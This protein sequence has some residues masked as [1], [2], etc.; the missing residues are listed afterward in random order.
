MDRPNARPEEIDE[1]LDL[2]IDLG[3]NEDQLD[4]Q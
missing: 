1:V 3:A 2:F 4:F